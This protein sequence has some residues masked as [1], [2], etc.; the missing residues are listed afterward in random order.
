ML[1]QEIRD[2]STVEVTYQQK[3]VYQKVKCYAEIAKCGESNSIQQSESHNSEVKSVH[4]SDTKIEA[5]HTHLERAFRI[6]FQKLRL[7]RK[8]T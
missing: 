3:K 7:D 4:I 6:F 8:K 2:R 1:P 5:D